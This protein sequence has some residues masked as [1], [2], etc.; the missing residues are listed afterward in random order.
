MIE[1]Q[2]RRILVAATASF[3]RGYERTAVEDIVKR[4]GVSRRTVYDLFDGKD[5][6]FRAAHSG[7]LASL[8]RRL[9]NAGSRPVRLDA[10]LDALLTWAVAEPDPAL[11][12]V[13]PALV[14][15]PNVGLARERL[16]AVL[17]P[18]LGL[19][20]PRSTTGRPSLPEAL[21]GGLAEVIAGRLLGGDSTTLPSLAPALSH[22]ILAYRPALE[23][24]PS[25]RGARAA[26]AAPG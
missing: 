4:A 18:S 24:R 21:L 23:A 2:R 16:F 5:A 20:A 14:A 9:R 15:G 19:P 8:R 10:A 13:A 6:I 11:L 1:Y 26:A 12:V 3:A 17:G 25:T 22:F 7:A